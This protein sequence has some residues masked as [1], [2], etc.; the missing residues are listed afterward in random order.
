MPW[1]DL[2]FIPLPFTNAASCW[3]VIPGIRQ[4]G[5]PMQPLPVLVRTPESKP[6]A[7]QSF[8]RA[9]AGPKSKKSLGGAKKNVTRQSLRPKSNKKVNR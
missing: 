7:V 9:P 1:R 6:G 4:R 3:K 2:P 8:K 5:A